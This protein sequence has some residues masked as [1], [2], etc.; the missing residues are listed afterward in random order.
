MFAVLCFKDEPTDVCSFSRLL[1]LFTEANVLK[2]KVF[3]TV[4]LRNVIA[5]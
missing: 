4:E 2:L 1:V 3:L 5:W